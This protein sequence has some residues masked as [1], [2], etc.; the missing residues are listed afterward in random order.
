MVSELFNSILS[1]SQEI[2][3]CHGLLGE[4]KGKLPGHPSKE[5]EL[6]DPDVRRLLAVELE[7]D[8]FE[9]LRPLFRKASLD[10]RS[11]KDAISALHLLKVVKVSMLVVAYPLRTMNFGVFV[12]HL[13]AENCASRTARLMVAIAEGDRTR[14]MPWIDEIAEVISVDEDSLLVQHAISDL[15]GVAPRSSVNLMVSLIVDPDGPNQ[16]SVLAQS[17]D[18]STVGVFVSTEEA[19]SV[20]EPLS[21]KIFLSGDGAPI[22]VQGRVARLAE[23]KLDSTAGFGMQFMNLSEEKLRLLDEF[24]KTLR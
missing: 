24:L 10:L 8:A 2:N 3:F 4:R 13:R 7:A 20:G 9:A 22:Q 6:T 19:V 5:P 18:L 12:Q 21:C 16:R 11:V 1:I 14:L 23:P 17:R 15:L